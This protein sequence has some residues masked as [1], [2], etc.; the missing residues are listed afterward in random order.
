[1]N[2]RVSL[3]E[4]A[5]LR[6]LL[7]PE[8]FFKR[9]GGSFVLVRLDERGGS[10]DP[11]PWAFGETSSTWPFPGTRHTHISDDTATLTAETEQWPVPDARGDACLFPLKNAAFGIKGECLL[12]RGPKSDL[13]IMERSISRAHAGFVRN[14]KELLLSDCGSKNGTCVNGVPIRKAQKLSSGDL[15]SFG[16]IQ[17]LLLSSADFWAHV[18]EMCD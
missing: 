4:F 9:L 2:P 7:S 10:T 8:A 14:A 1:L 13:R 16:D 12:G 5:R 3:D 15:L 6:V 17:M 18:S 11:V